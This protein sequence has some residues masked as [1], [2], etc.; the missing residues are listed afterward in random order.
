M[1]NH[2]VNS[3]VKFRASLFGQKHHYYNRPTVRLNQQL[4]DWI[5]II[6]L[7]SSQDVLLTTSIKVGYCS[8]DVSLPAEYLCC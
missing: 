1:S 5:R 2:P 8:S 7:K 4:A 6:F 3:F